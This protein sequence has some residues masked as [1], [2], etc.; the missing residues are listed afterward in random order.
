MYLKSVK[1]EKYW[2]SSI[3]LGYICLMFFMETLNNPIL[4]I[5]RI[6][7]IIIY[8]I[9]FIYSSKGCNFYLKNHLLGSKLLTLFLISLP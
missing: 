1:V 2:S 3:N 8:G 5:F 4:R 9:V 7:R 6:N